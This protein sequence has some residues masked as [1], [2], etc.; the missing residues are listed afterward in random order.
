MV[1]MPMITKAYGA[2]GIPINWIVDLFERQI[3][4]YSNR[5]PDGYETCE[6]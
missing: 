1:R 4:L 3:E 6:I 2:A 5:G